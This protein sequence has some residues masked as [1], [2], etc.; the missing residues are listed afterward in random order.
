MFCMNC[1][2]QL[3]DSAKFCFKC[4][5]PIK[6]TIPVSDFEL[7]Q[8]K[9]S[10]KKYILGEKYEI[11]LDSDL[12]DYCN[13]R[14]P[15]ES[16]IELQELEFSKFYYTNIHNVDDVINVGI[17]K[18]LN[19]IQEAVRLGV[20]VLMTYGVDY[21]SF[22]SLKNEVLSE[23]ANDQAENLLTLE[24]SL[25]EIHSILSE[26]DSAKT[27]WRGG[28]F[29]IS[30]AIEGAIKAEVLNIGTNTL[31]GMAKFITGNTAEDKFKK[32][33][34]EI[35]ESKDF[36]KIFLDV[37]DDYVCKSVVGK[38]Y[39]ILINENK[40][41]EIIL[42][43]DKASNK[44]ENVIEMLDLGDISPNKAIDMLC[45]CIAMN[46][47]DTYFEELIIGIDKTLANDIFSMV[48][49]FG[50]KIQLAR[51][52]TTYDSSDP[53]IGEKLRKI[54]RELGEYTD[55]NKVIPYLAM[56][57]EDLNYLELLY[58][59]GDEFHSIYLA[60]NEGSEDYIINTKWKHV[61]YIG[62][63]K[64]TATSNPSDI[65]WQ[66]Y[67]IAFTNIT[68][69]GSS[70]LMGN[71]KDVF[72]KYK[73]FILLWTGYMYDKGLPGGIASDNKKAES[74]YLKALSQEKDKNNIVEFMVAY[75][76]A[77]LSFFAN[78]SVKA[79]W[80]KMCKEIG[81]KINKTDPLIHS[82]VLC[83]LILNNIGTGWQYA[84]DEERKMK[85]KAEKLADIALQNDDPLEAGIANVK[86]N[87]EFNNSSSEYF[88]RA[89]NLLA[90]IIEKGG[91][92][93]AIA[94]YWY[95]RACSSSKKAEKLYRN[96]FDTFLSLPVYLPHKNLLNCYMGYIYMKRGDALIDS[97]H[98]SS[99]AKKYLM[100]ASQSKE[101]GGAI[102][103]FLLS[104]LE[105][106]ERKYSLDYE[107][108]SANF[109]HLA[110]QNVNAASNIEKAGYYLY[111]YLNN[112]LSS[113]F[114]SPKQ[115]NPTVEKGLNK[116]ISLYKQVIAGG[117]PLEKGIACAQL[118]LLDSVELHEEHRQ[119][120]E[121]Y[122]LPLSET[123]T[124]EGFI[125]SYWRSIIYAEI[126]EGKFKETKS[127]L[128]LLE[129]TM[130]KFHELTDFNNATISEKRVRTEIRNTDKVETAMKSSSQEE[131]GHKREVA[132]VS[133]G[134]EYFNIGDYANA[135]SEFMKE[136]NMGGVLAGQAA[137]YLG[138][139]YGNGLGAEI[140][141]SKA[142]LWIDIAKDMGDL[143]T[144]R[145]ALDWQK[146]IKTSIKTC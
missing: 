32:F 64:V 65:D 106:R 100:E 53:K 96:A 70:L 18:C 88:D 142:L 20:S 101:Y 43:E 27:Y 46:P 102:A 87:I 38:I 123:S 21:V 33:K 4:G 49:D 104:R 61:R 5:I 76:M 23:Y 145:I 77:H 117:S 121:M 13:L 71:D 133:K 37:L 140:D 75:N 81:Q 16:Y 11:N 89:M 42:E 8:E 60:S 130:Q 29:G 127:S 125:A 131:D 132:G 26:E 48:E 112:R 139:M 103:L 111:M 17:P 41:N 143:N 120:A 19:I 6:T 91:V 146:K 50:T 28:G 24:E 136:Y 2:T 10:G 51:E 58:N 92:K 1:G 134:I 66:S 84:Y 69:N 82:T 7:M 52:I 57:P 118:S 124:E 141:L 83:R 126:N 63:G 80:K 47:Y 67:D 144:Q 12:V 59:H 107:E 74:Y 9:K 122:L 68:I 78:D 94:S 22:N 97:L 72:D 45:Q 115:A 90:P 31:V 95:A 62:I 129:Q 25:N 79:R 116:S 36:E 34:K 30:G 109:I 138:V 54:H 128:R 73:S 99:T 14:A 114:D 98:A 113:G 40:I 137:L 135:I 44:S 3:P 119:Q 35:Y 85:K 86:R 93:G 39:K 15:L 56:E 55:F 110:R 108:I 105:R